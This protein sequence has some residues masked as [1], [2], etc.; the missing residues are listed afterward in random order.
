[1]TIILVILV[2]LPA[3]III[4]HIV[5]ISNLMTII[6]YFLIAVIEMIVLYYLV[7]HA[8]ITISATYKARRG[9]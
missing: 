4:A 2:A 7:K 6:I 1:M 8:E 5:G 9:K 3:I